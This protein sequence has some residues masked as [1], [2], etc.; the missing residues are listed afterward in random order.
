MASK[1]MDAKRRWRNPFGDGRAAER[2]M[3]KVAPVGR[4]AM[5]TIDNNTEEARQFTSVR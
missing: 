2:I 5:R 4:H 3:A 1:M